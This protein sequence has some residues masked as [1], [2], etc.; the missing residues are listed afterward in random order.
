MC[1]SRR[2]A[3]SSDTPPVVG[4]RYQQATG[5]RPATAKQ[6]SLQYQRH[7]LPATRAS[8][9]P[10]HRTAAAA[11]TR[12]TRGPPSTPVTIRPASSRTKEK[13]VKNL[14][15]PSPSARSGGQVGL[16]LPGRYHSG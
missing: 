12:E 6:A 14:F 7:F 9:S 5:P 15:A 11:A 16:G 10:S 2:S 1:A 3:S 13:N 8:S 4:T